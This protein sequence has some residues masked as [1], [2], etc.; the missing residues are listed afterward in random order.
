MEQRAKSP[1]ERLTGTVVS[2]GEQ[3]YYEVCGQGE[4]V[5]FCHGAGGNHAIWYQQV[6]AFVPRYQV[7]TWDQRGFGR[8][9]NH[10]GKAGPRSAVGDLGALLDHLGVE[11]AHLVGQSM[12]GWVI[13]G[14]A[15]AYPHRVLSLVMADTL[16]GIRISG[17]SDKTRQ[18]RERVGGA[19]LDPNLAVGCEHPC[20]APD[21]AAREPARAFLYSQIPSLAP[22]MPLSALLEL[23]EVTWTAEELERLKAPVLFLVGSLDSLFPAEDIR[24]AAALVAGAKVVE[25]PGCGHS[26]YF[27]D[28]VRWNG[29]VLDFLSAH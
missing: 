9:T 12:G 3:I 18:A 24:E 8:S 25:I 2:G 4:P 28:P 11:R 29:A 10:G 20:L 23:S 6:P 17:S 16:G 14:F 1:A 21:F 19:L 7:I 5:V 26:P 15:L 22:P 13:L 27:E